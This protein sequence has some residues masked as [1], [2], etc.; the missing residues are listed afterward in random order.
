M[1]L[2]NK[3]YEMAIK[4]AGE[5]ER[6]FYNSTNISKKELKSIAKTA[7]QAS[8]GISSSFRNGMNETSGIF[9]NIEKIGK[10]AFKA[11]ATAAATTATACAAYSV[12]VGMAF[13]KQMSV[14]KSISNATAGDM[15]TLSK[16]AKEMGATTKFSASEAGQA[17]EYMAMA[18]WKTSQM[19]SGIDGIMNLAAASDAELGTTSDIVTDALSAFKM[20]ADDAEHFSD[21]LAQ[22]SSNANTDVLKMGETFKYVAPLAGAL[23]YSVEDVALGIGLM[24]NSGIKASQAGTA[25]RSWLTRMAKPTKESGQAMK[26]LNLSITDS[27]GNMLSY[28]DVIYNTKR[29]FDKLTPAEQSS[30]AAMLAGKTGMSGLL[31]VVN[32][33][34]EDINKLMDSI[35]N[36]NGAAKKMAEIRLDNLAGDV[37]ILKSGLEGLGIQIYEEINEP[38]RNAAQFITDVVSNI[39]DE[40]RAGN[41]LP[42]IIRNSKEFGNAV[43]DF[44]QPI[45]MIGEWLWKHPDVIVSTLTGIGTTLIAYKIANNV[46]KLAQAF[47]AL[48]PA[49]A[50]ILGI[51]GAVAVISGIATYVSLAN[52]EMKR[53]NLSAHFGKISLSL[54]DLKEVADSIIRTDSLGKIEESIAAINDMAEISETIDSSLKD[55]NRM[56]WKVSVGMELLDSDK[57]SYQDN[58]TSYIANI[59]EL[60]KQKQYAVNLS[61]GALLDDGIE[62]S[63]VIDKINAFYADKESE[64]QEL[65]TKLNETVTNAFKDGLLDM[66]EAKEITELQQQMADIQSAVASS[67]FDAKLELLDVKYSGG[68][69]DAESF[70]NL[71][72]E[73]NTQLA[74]AKENFEESFTLGVSNAKVMLDDGAI[75]QE[76][77][78]NMVEE[79][80]KGY[81]EN[82][83]ELEIKANNFETNTIKEQYA[84]EIAKLEP[85]LQNTVNDALNEVINGINN[86]GLGTDKIAWGKMLS[87]VQNTDGISESTKDAITDLYNLLKPNVEMLEELKAQYKEFGLKI[88]ESL[89][90]GLNDSNMLGTIAGNADSIWAYVGQSIAGSSELPSALE[91]ALSTGKY[92]PQ[93]VGEGIIENKRQVDVSIG[94]FHDYVKNAL[95]GK[96]SGGF[97]VNVPI[98]VGN[99]PK[100]ER[101][102]AQLPGHADGGIFDKP[103]IAWFA[104]GGD[105]EAAIPINNSQRSATLWAETG[106]LLGLYNNSS[107]M[108]FDSLSNEVVRNSS[109]VNSNNQS[110][111][112]TIQVQYSPQYVIQGNTRIEDVMAADEMSQERFNR[113]ME[114]Y[115]REKLRTN[116]GS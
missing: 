18:G 14:V 92:I 10:K 80:K 41:M 7:S 39:S 62:K 61:V 75:N 3:E 77:Y 108:D 27:K 76:E 48:S 52:K 6:S 11:V 17:M 72:E 66:D 31:A 51:A 114:N 38:L 115:E 5:I 29:A 111:S 4:I 82:I 37:T 112:R 94:S 56:N 71:Q 65:G 9:N 81:L 70:Q 97:D 96:F 13:E 12:K 1:R 105:K 30:Y 54:E 68:K 58:I 60:V 35:E 89:S 28:A 42:T 46:M 116:F 84:D 78:N 33:S 16:K 45:I 87:E 15:E 50:T 90:E 64:L 98:R 73:V 43:F 79:L 102:A 67:K 32:A 85:E 23:T 22:A 95:N 104:E 53:Q 69:L 59:Q 86:G 24:A 103:H 74:T 47:T 109:T 21:V 99:I 36:C 88:P 40:L 34:E 100:W 20:S 19:L 110:E 83:G 113:M 49:G 91:S 93:K 2:A 101:N 44:A 55:I 107:P 25:M 57:Q 63:N 106:K 26:D 8:T